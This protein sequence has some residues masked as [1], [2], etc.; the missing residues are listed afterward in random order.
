MAGAAFILPAFCIVCAIGWAYQRFGA[1]PETTALLRG[2][3]PVMIAIV[4]QAL[5]GLGRTAVKNLPLAFAGGAAFAAAIIRPGDE[6]AILAILGMACGAGAWLRAS[7]SRV[8]ALVIPMPALSLL[9]GTTSA[10]AAAR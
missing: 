2:I 1:L 7:R 10:A 5:L 6:V 8:T 4:I 9:A 3:K